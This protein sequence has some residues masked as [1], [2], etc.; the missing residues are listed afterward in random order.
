MMSGIFLNLL[1]I[2][3][4]NKINDIT[5]ISAF[6]PSIDYFLILVWILGLVQSWS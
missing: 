6:C 4:A 3:C 1:H 5:D 2:N